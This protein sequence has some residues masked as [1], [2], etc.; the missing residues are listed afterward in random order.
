MHFLD[1]NI[2]RFITTVIDCA[3][4]AVIWTAIKEQF[5][6]HRV[7]SER[8]LWS[9]PYATDTQ[10]GAALPA[11]TGPCVF[12]GDREQSRNTGEGM[13]KKQKTKTN[14]QMY[15]Y[16]RRQIKCAWKKHHLMICLN[17]A[18][19]KCLQRHYSLP[20]PALKAAAG[21]CGTEESSCRP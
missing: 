1:V 21:W 12:A 14:R 5:S 8:D 16:K 11:L 7:W 15:H 18:D 17:H 20:S 2:C 6:P 3:F 19:Q 10:S 4:P 9:C 13:S